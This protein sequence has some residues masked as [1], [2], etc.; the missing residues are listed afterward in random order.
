MDNEAS[1]KILQEM[2]IMYSRRGT[3]TFDAIVAISRSS[4]VRVRAIRHTTGMTLPK[5]VAFE[6]ARDR[7]ILRTVR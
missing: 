6:N 1:E 4:R 7:A 2:I 3:H 5:V